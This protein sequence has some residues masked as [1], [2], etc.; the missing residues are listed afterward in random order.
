MY[1]EGG[2]E[3]AF[4][5]GGAVAYPAADVDE[6]VDVEVV[7]CAGRG[8]EERKDEVE[9]DIDEEDNWDL[10]AFD[11]D[12]RGGRVAAA[13]CFAISV[14]DLRC[15]NESIFDILCNDFDLDLDDNDECDP[16]PELPLER[17]VAAVEA[18]AE[19]R[20][21]EDEEGDECSLD[22]SFEWY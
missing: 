1:A 6:D 22:W 7:I 9:D 3:R 19:E 5:V 2:G 21:E 11:E 13:C 12:G 8:W 14:L 20:W 15:P 18:D 4:G 17:D 10:W 16:D